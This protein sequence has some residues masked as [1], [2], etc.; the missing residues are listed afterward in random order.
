MPVTAAA[1]SKLR[2][3]LDC[4]KVW[5]MGSNATR[6]WKGFETKRS[7]CIS[8]NIPEYAW[9]DWE[10]LR[11]ARAPAKIRL[12]HMSN[13]IYSLTAKLAS[14]VCR[15]WLRGLTVVLVCGVVPSA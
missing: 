1:W 3:V 11:I 7:W 14:S 2:T 12:G 5:I 13:T 4:S 9:K 15:V 8:G 10:D 6:N